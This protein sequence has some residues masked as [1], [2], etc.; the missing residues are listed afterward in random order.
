MLKMSFFPTAILF[1]IAPFVVAAEQ[2]NNCR[3]K[4][5]AMVWLAADA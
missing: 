1:A 2:A 5:G 4:G 3:L